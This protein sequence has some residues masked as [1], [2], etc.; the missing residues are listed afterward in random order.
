MTNLYQYDS[1]NRLTNSVW[2]LNA[3]TLASFYYQLG[4]T[5]NR[6]NLVEAVNGSWRTNQ[7]SYDPLYRLT[8][9]TI[10]GASY[11]SPQSLGYGYDPVGNRTNRT[12]TSGLNLTNQSFTFNTNDWLKTDAYDNNGN[13]LW[14]TNGS[15]QGPYYYDYENRLIN[16][17]NSVYL[18]YNGDGVRVK[19]TANGTN[20]YYLVDD[21]NPSGY[22]QVLEEWTASGGSPSLSRVY[23]YGLSLVSQKQG[24]TTYYFGYDG[25]GSTRFLL[26]SSGAIAESYAY[27]TYGN[28]IAGP[29]TPSTVYLYCAQQYD[30]DL[31]LYLNRARYW[32]TG[33]GRFW[34][35]DDQEGDQQEPKSL[36][37]YTYCE[38]DPVDGIDPSG[39][40]VYFVERK[41][42]KGYGPE[43]WP[44]GA[45]HG[46]LCFT[47]P[48][49]PGTGDPFTTGQHLV[50]SFSWH[51]NKWHYHGSRAPGRIWE[52]D[53]TSDWKPPSQHLAFRVTTDRDA[54]A[55]L[56]NCINTWKEDTG[57]GYE[58]G[59]PIW[60]TP[61]HKNEIG[62][63]RHTPAPPGG[64]YY[65]VRGQNC[66][67]WATIM[68]KQSN[69]QVNPAVYKAILNYN[70]GFGAANQ[71]IK[72][73]RSAYDVRTLNR[74][75]AGMNASSIAGYDLSGF[76]AGF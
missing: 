7:W 59:A 71:V 21:R 6:T 12:S 51:P 41:L 66:V 10:G 47:D 38:S 4:L 62:S 31:G 54:Q 35:R 24:G 45:G 52:N 55:S 17:N 34:T 39:N 36:N 25:H 29:T 19:K 57:C 76:D 53:T 60:E 68:L 40:A 63:V 49:D 1:L 27:D 74:L 28:L 65:S 42:S 26:N 18:A 43:T 64:V 61:A 13:T 30:F 50:D 72:G 2:N 9:E 73:W 22:A 14:S 16:Y 23:N 44:L 48:S 67:W 46:Y 69:I 58:S 5:G 56:L 15:V 33:T 75:P 37:L 8:N 11:T 20:I 32:N 3:S 70:W